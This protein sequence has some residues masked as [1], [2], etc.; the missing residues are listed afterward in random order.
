MPIKNIIFDIGNVMVRWSP[1]HII[2]MTFPQLHAVEQERLREQ[3]F[4]S[5]LWMQL[6]LGQ[7]S[8]HDAKAQFL[9]ACEHLN[10][11]NINTLF[12]HIKSSQDLLPGMLELLETLH[13]KG[14]RLFALTDNIKEI[15]QYL[16]IRY[17]FWKYFLHVTVSAEIGLV[18]PNKEIFEYAMRTNHLQYHETLFIDDHLPNITTAK[19]L[20][21]QTILFT[22]Q[23]NCIQAL[24]HLSV[25]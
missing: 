25:L 20:G 13:L 16:Q 14:Y 3:I 1:I 10:S 19:A 17:D 22:D 6:N 18:K 21:L 4:K 2:Q 12:D 15:I 8:E 24:E 5:D 7:I 9:N 11:T 23:Q